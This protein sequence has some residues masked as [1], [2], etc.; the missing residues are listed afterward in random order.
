MLRD[1]LLD[2]RG[3]GAG[4]RGSAVV[5]FALVLPLVLVLALAMLQIGLVIR[6]RLQVEA[7]ARAAARM[8]AVTDDGS[9]IRAAALR[10][11]PA[12]DPAVTEVT[13]ERA[14][15]RGSPVTTSVDGSSRLRVPLVGWLLP[16]SVDLHA[17]VTA[18]QEF[19]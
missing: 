5:E 3:A 6:D 19:G 7:A 13:V 15:A 9:S 1:R 18:R 14:G 10:A 16:E 8:A 11:A 2:A 17:S 4:G 12:L